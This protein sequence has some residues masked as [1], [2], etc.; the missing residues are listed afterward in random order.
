M[1]RTL[2]GA[3][4]KAPHAAR[5]GQ[6]LLGGGCRC[7]LPFT[8]LLSPRLPLHSVYVLASWECDT[9]SDV[10]GSLRRAVSVL[11]AP[12]LRADEHQGASPSVCSFDKLSLAAPLC[13]TSSQAGPRARQICLEHFSA[14]HAMCR[15]QQNVCRGYSPRPALPCLKS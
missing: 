8:R 4:V 9:H 15:R 12:H 1:T 2:V 13:L 5:Y 6:H 3:L 10:I 7:S 14:H 11:R